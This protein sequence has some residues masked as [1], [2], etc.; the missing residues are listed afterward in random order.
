MTDLRRQSALFDTSKLRKAR[1]GVIGSGMI[2]NFLCAYL[3]GLGIGKIALIDNSRRS[4][5]SI[6]FL[7]ELSNEKSSKIHRMA[8]TLKRINP[9]ND[10]I[11]YFSEPNRFFIE[12][13]DVVVDTTNNPDYKYRM[14]R[15]CEGTGKLLISCSSTASSA[16][17]NAYKFGTER[18]IFL[19]DMLLREFRGILQ[20]TFTSGLAAALAADEIRKDVCPVG[21]DKRLE[22]RIDYSIM[23]PGR[24]GQADPACNMNEDV[25]LQVLRN[26]R[27][28]KALVVGAGG[29]GTYVLIN[30]ALLGMEIDIYDGDTVEGHNLNR[31]II[32]YDAIGENKAREAAKKLRR[33]RA[34]ATGNPRHLTQEILDGKAGPGEGYDLVFSCVDSWAARRMLNNYCRLTGT[35]LFDGSVET[36]AC[37]TEAFRPGETHC[38]E[39]SS[40]YRRRTRDEKPTSCADLPANVVMPNAMAGALMVAEAMHA[41]APETIPAAKT[42]KVRYDSNFKSRLVQEKTALYCKSEGYYRHDC[43]CHT[44]FDR[45]EQHA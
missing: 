16:A 44:H 45:G 38:L 7:V 33:L 15:H 21:T 27:D 1:V 37:S 9:E 39:C 20:G 42:N 28:K 41:I 34:K 17:V 8:D 26:A 13:C 10:V 24:T 19:D 14:F 11:P 29:I 18:S 4:M 35:P 31:Q 23:S 30:L 3:A 6:D 2:S 12:S 40:D 32:H 22:Q 43:R 36:F 25:A 5:K